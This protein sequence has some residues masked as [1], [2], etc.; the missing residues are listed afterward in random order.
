MA[1]KRKAGNSSSSAATA[2]KRRKGVDLSKLPSWFREKDFFEKQKKMMCALHSVNNALGSAVFTADDFTRVGNR[3]KAMKKSHNL[4]TYG[5]G[6]GGK[7][8]GF[9]GIEVVTAVLRE[10]GMFV[11]RV[12]EQNL[13]EYLLTAMGRMIL[14]V[15]LKP[16]HTKNVKHLHWLAVDGNSRLI[17]D[18][19]VRDGPMKLTR[20][21]LKSVMRY[22]IK[23]VY[24][25]G[26]V[27]HWPR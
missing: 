11:Q 8:K 22:G 24:F 10:R 21:N 7:S 12:R 15:H 26:D 6:S 1:A 13:M 9:W 20:K 16:K 17:L 4:P 3:L 18:S 2:Q 19:M 23:N 5:T 25:L 14:T 27:V